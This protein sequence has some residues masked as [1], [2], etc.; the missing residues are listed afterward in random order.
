MASAQAEDP[1]FVAEL[2][3][4][5][6][7]AAAAG[8]VAVRRALDLPRNVQ[9]KGALDLV[10]DTDKESEVAV[11]AV[12][13]ASFPQHALLGEEGG[14]SGN[15]DSPYLWAVDPLDGT[16]NFSHSYPSFAVS[17]AVTRRGVPLA[18]CVVEFCGGPRAWTTRTFT[19]AVGQGASCNGEPL[20]HV[21]SASELRR[22]LLVTG[23]GYD[24][25]K[26]WEENLALF[27]LFTDVCQGVRRLGAASVDLCH[28][29]LGV[30][31]CYWEFQLKPWDMAAGALILQ[32]AGGRVTKGDGAPFSIFAKSILASNGAIHGA[33][34]EHVGAACARLQADGFDL[35]DWYI[36]SGYDVQ[37]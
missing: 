12:I 18:A 16:T 37:R 15:L 6:A 11:L 21:S 35:Q 2:R 19:A 17:V 26:D 27:R 14:V 31:D 13:R 33:V 10:T 7:R 1:Q 8:A 23:F 30:V 5:A 28:V 32:E 3:D 4:V 22:S 36:P 25:G 20:H 9:Y 24:H 29:A 34:L